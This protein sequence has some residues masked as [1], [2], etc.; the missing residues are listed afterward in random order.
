M[1]GMG[2]HCR[3]AH[4]HFCPCTLRYKFILLERVAETQIQFSYQVEV[5]NRSRSSS[6][7]GLNKCLELRG[8]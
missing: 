3:Q 1:E 7:Y 2:T 4:N 5:V 8:N 6:Y